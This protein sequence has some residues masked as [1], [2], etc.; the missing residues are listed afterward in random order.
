M[1]NPEQNQDIILCKGCNTK[2]FTSE[3]PKNRLN[4]IMKS[5]NKCKEK[6]ERLKCEHKRN[7]YLCKECKGSAICEHNREKYSCKECKGLSICEHN[8]RKSQCKTCKGASICE[9]NTRRS[10]CTVCKGGSI[11][12]HGR[13]RSTC[14][15][16]DGSGICE[17]KLR[18]SVCV[19]CGGGSVCEHKIQRRNCRICD[20][21]GYLSKIV[22]C[23]VT[24][25]L[26]AQKSKKTFQYVG[27]GVDEF[28]SHIES[29]FEE[30][31]TWENYGKEWH[32]DHIVPLKY[33]NPTLEE[34]TKR[35]HYLNTQ[36]MKAKDNIRKGNRYIGK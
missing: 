10:V 17:H 8:N 35:L 26:K 16:C 30:W 18:K 9:H 15:E 24:Q 23:E 13:I 6:R 2:R 12:Q 22:R 7:K 33:N 4:Q 29:Q 27:C 5:C 19:A 21:N 31:M 3:F 34:V 11:C 36:P 20:F 25:A 32:I 28:K 1:E 14:K